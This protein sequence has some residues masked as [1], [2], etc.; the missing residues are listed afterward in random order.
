MIP[1]VARVTGEVGHSEI[2]QNAVEF[3]LSSPSVA[4]IVASLTRIGQA[5]LA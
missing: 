5:L 4:P 1:Y 3:I 2:A